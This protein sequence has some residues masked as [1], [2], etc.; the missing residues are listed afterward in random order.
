M[1]ALLG[2]A[3]L[4]RGAQILALGWAA[5]LAVSGPGA[6]QAPAGTV[7]APSGARATARAS[8]PGDQAPAR[9]HAPV[10][11]TSASR[12]LSDTARAL[13]LLERATFGVRAQDLVDVLRAGRAAWLDRQLHP[14][15]IDDSALET[16]LAQYPA[17]AMDAA[18]L[19]RAYPP[20]AALKRQAKAGAGVVGDS[21]MM[22]DGARPA[23][24]R[25]RAR[26]ALRAGAD[27]A[28]ADGAGP[29]AGRRPAGADSAAMMDDPGARARRGQAGAAAVDPFAAMRPARMV[30]DFA[31]ARLA[32][33]VY[34][35]RQLQEVMTDFWFNHFNVFVGKGADRYLVAG[36]EREAIRPYVFGRFEDMLK[37]TA[38]HPAMLFYLDNWMSAVPDTT[39]PQY[40]RQQERIRRFQAMT[41][42]QRQALV[43]SGRLTQQQL[44]RLSQ[45]V[46]NAGRR[47]AGINENYARELMELHTLGVDGGYTQQD[48]IAVARAFTGWT[49]TRARLGPNAPAG[50]GVE[51]V[52]RP[53]LHDRGEK[54]ALGTPLRPGRGM[55]DGLD[56]LHMLATS[57]VTARHLAHELVE[58]FVT[59]RP[60]SAMVERIARVFLDTDGDLRAVTRALFTDPGF[61]DP[62]LVD[63]KLKTP[64]EL[65]AS[66][67]RVTDADM[68]PG[69]SRAVL[70]ALRTLGELPYGASFPTGYP[71]AS[72]EWT[73]GGAMLNR[74]NFALALAAGRL[75]H[76]RVDPAVLLGGSARA[77]GA[78]G[79][80]APV[81][82]VALRP[83]Q[84][85]GLAGDA[86]VDA[87]HALARAFL[88]GR[89]T[90]AL[91]ATV[92]DEVARQPE[93]GSG[94]AL[95][96]AAGLLLGSPAFQKR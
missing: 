71:A 50:A 32:R 66:A 53:E 90:R 54:V 74:M 46:N 69:P 11:G 3:P 48:V 51:F 28:L 8:S 43:A 14:E 4:R 61:D 12:P 75:D 77:A 19:Y 9:A 15:R 95:A 33:A 17:A 26:A 85:R 78:A 20:A 40:V 5:T 56:V 89:D 94:M 88:P 30:A 83:A 21:A 6:A 18:A 23:R 91:E 72:A 10:A 82:A 2:Q 36:Y 52:F 7:R 35:E 16:R 67:L 31:G 47:K 39:S 24:G 41:P 58:R 42:E 62:R 64:L 92:R 79:A 87:V 76:V 60:D 44:D 63:A 13:H 34:S 70:Q 57:P 29:R 84:G 93:T 59:D 68:G 86:G 38:S 49:I 22:E 81:D 96:E 37:A 45:V 1:R 27:T 25:E 73:N 65:V 55:E 80:S